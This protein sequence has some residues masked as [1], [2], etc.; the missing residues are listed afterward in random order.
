MINFQ[1][2]LQHLIHLDIDIVYTQSF[3]VKQFRDLQI[4]TA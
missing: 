4:L 2:G 3:L 1:S